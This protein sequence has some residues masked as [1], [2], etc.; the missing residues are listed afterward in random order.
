MEMF[1]GRALF[2]TCALGA[3]VKQ[4]SGKNED[5][6]DFAQKLFPYCPGIQIKI[7]SVFFT[8]CLSR[9]LGIS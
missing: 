2:A 5:F 3:M 8:T 7:N 1:M 6:E 4:G 9:W